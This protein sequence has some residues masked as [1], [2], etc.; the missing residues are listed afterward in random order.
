MNVIILKKKC[1]LNTRR[2]K[3]Q[4]PMVLHT[5]NPALCKAEAG[6]SQVVALN[7]L[8]W[9]CLKW[10]NERMNEWE[11]DLVWRSWIQS[12]VPKTKQPSNNYLNFK[13]T[14]YVSE[15]NVKSKIIK[16]LHKTTENNFTTSEYRHVFR[17]DREGVNQNTKQKI[18]L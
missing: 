17:Q 13:I 3:F 10:M 7:N 6:W 16:F 12:S 14:L 8:A 2:K 5:C 11:G 9:L 18:L 15:L 4:Q 1:L